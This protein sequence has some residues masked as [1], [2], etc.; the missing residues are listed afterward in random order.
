VRRAVTGLVCVAWQGAMQA[1]SVTPSLQH[2][3]RACPA[4]PVGVYVHY[5]DE[6][7][8][9]Y[10]AGLALVPTA[11]KHVL[12]TFVFHIIRLKRGFCDQGQLGLP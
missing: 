2:H 8:V 12:F 11:P 9:A 10:A 5:S 3:L 4:S 6:R 1:N 7:E